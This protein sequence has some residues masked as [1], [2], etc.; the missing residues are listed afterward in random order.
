MLSSKAETAFSSTGYSNWRKA[1]VRFKEHE[2]SLAH[3]DAINAFQSSQSTSVSSL[4]SSEMRR[5][6]EQRKNSLIKQITALK[7]LLRQ[8]L[9]IRNDHSG[10][11]NLTLMLEMVMNEN[12]WVAAKK[13]QSPDNEIIKL[14]GHKVLRSVISD[15]QFHKWYSMM[16]D[17]TRDVSNREQL[18]VTMRWVS[19][20]RKI[21]VVCFN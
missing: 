10:G 19:E 20:L 21:F 6:Q 2:L 18:V 4:L 3:R 5:N 11:S 17:E 7:F 8:G 14:M 9:P 13:Y 15:I 1:T 16:A 12:S